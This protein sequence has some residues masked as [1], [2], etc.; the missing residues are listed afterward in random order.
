MVSKGTKLEDLLCL[1]RLWIADAARHAFMKLVR[2][3]LRS[4]NEVMRN[5]VLDDGSDNLGNNFDI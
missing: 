4:M 1:L 5:R 2:D 3:T